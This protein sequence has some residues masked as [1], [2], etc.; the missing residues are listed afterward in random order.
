MVDLSTKAGACRWIAE[1]GRH[2]FGELWSRLEPLCFNEHGWPVGVAHVDHFDSLDQRPLPQNSRELLIPAYVY[3]AASFFCLDHL[4]D[5]ESH[6]EFEMLAGSILIPKALER[7]AVTFA[8]HGMPIPDGLHEAAHLFQNFVQAM[9]LEKDIRSQPN[10]REEELERQHVVGRSWLVIYMYK[11]IQT[12]KGNHVDAEAQ[13]LLE[14]AIYLLQ[15]GDDWGD[16]RED[17]RAGN[18]TSFIRE[19]IS[20]MGRSPADVNELERY[21]YLSGQYERRGTFVSEGLRMVEQRLMA[22]YGQGARSILAMVRQCRELS[23]AVVD[24][25]GR[26]KAGLAPKELPARLH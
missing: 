7:V 4:F 3:L 23:E 15:L 6:N 19:C 22:N 24:N 14:D 17:F 2:D 5:G 10:L 18:L 11:T 21:I 20:G 26:V 25:F 13:Q 16:W 8:A 9:L 12:L 1:Q